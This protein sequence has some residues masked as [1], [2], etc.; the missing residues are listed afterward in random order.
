MCDDIIN[1]YFFIKQ[2][3]KA[4]KKYLKKLQKQNHTQTLLQIK[5][6]KYI[7]TTTMATTQTKNHITKT[8]FGIIKNF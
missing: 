6:F 7:V 2:N 5:Y 1:S 4:N 3:G 8:R